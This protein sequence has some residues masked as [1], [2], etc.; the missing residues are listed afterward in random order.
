METVR[1]VGMW[2][3][4]SAKAFR[5]RSVI[6]GRTGY[7]KCAWSTRNNVENVLEVCPADVTFDAGCRLQVICRL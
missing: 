4:V 7:A 5:R 2:K 6:G 1:Q 3:D